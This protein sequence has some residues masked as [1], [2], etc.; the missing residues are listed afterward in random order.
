MHNTTASS[1]NS[2]TLRIGILTATSAVAMLALG[3]API[4]A[5]YYLLGASLLAVVVIVSTDPKMSQPVATLPMGLTVGVPAILA[6]LFRGTSLV[7]AIV[8]VLA[9]VVS[10]ATW[11]FVSTRYNATTVAAEPSDISTLDEP[12]DFAFADELMSKRHEKTAVTHDD[13]SATAA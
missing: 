8:P 9:L 10:S 4:P 2:I 5:L 3:F 6:L 7:W 13:S 12:S 11:M 1:L